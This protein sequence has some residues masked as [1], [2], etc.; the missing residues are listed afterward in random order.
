[1][2]NF[3]EIFSKVDTK[4]LPTPAHP[5]VEARIMRMRCNELKT[6]LRECSN[7]LNSIYDKASKN[8]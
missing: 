6:S 1:M 4:K 2:K 3:D 5:D 7:L 8:V